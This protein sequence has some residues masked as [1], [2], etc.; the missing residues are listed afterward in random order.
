MSSY[1]ESIRQRLVK[2]INTKAI[3]LYLFQTSGLNGLYY[4]IGL[5]NFKYITKSIRLSSTYHVC[6]YITHVWPT[7]CLQN[8]L[9]MIEWKFSLRIFTPWFSFQYST[10]TFRAEKCFRLSQIPYHSQVTSYPHALP[11]LLETLFH[12]HSPGQC[13]LILQDPVQMPIY[14]QSYSQ[15]HA[16]PYSDYSFIMT[17]ICCI[18]I[19]NQVSLTNH[20]FSCL[21]PQYLPHSGLVPGWKL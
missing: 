6:D 16:S 14:L 2:F 11:F 3:C 13:L 10:L 5:K 19:T 4:Y 8:C 20:A 15:P 7:V 1:F 9:Q 12:L 21:F 17:L 18:V